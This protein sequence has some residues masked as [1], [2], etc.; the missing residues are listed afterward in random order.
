MIFFCLLARGAAESSAEREEWPP[1]KNGGG[2]GG[3]Q[4]ADEETQGCCGPGLLWT[5]SLDC[6]T[7]IIIDLK[8]TLPFSL[9][10]FMLEIILF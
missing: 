10:S 4:R 9:C 1:V 7:G 2:P 5:D 3:P 6:A 8:N